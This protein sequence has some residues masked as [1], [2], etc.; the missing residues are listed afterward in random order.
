MKLT[1]QRLLPES[2][3]FSPM[4]KASTNRG[5]YK[6]RAV[7]QEIDNRRALVETGLSASLLPR[8]NTSGVGRMRVER[9]RQS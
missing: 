1:G 4:P 2:L 7:T 9:T 3:S 5:R 8:R 6:A